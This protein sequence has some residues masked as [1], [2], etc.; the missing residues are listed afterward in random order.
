MSRTG[1]RVGQKE[2]GASQE[3]E[4]GERE[5]TAPP[6][7]LPELAYVD[8]APRANLGKATA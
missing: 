3:Q 7:R 4:G 1:R 5:R 8:R 6:Q 2:R